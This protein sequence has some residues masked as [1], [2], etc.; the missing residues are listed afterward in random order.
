MC[1][2]CIFIS[3][4]LKKYV[5]W[6][7]YDILDPK[8]H[9]RKISNIQKKFELYQVFMRNF[10][11]Q[12]VPIFPLHILIWL[13]GIRTSWE[14]KSQKKKKKNSNIHKIFWVLPT[15]VDNFLCQTVPK[16]P[17]YTLFTYHACS[18]LLNQTNFT[19]MPPTHFFLT[20]LILLGIF[21][22]YCRI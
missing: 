15:F 19:S 13:G 9:T 2:I 5:N 22:L 16:F 1:L 11:C 20:K 7:C 10:V 6:G 14:R 18:M 12:N 21:Q 4:T 17:F 3:R 8:N